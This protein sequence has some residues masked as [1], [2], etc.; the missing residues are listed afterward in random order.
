MTR[1]ERAGPDFII[2]I[3]IPRPITGRRPSNPI[4]ECDDGDLCNTYLVVWGPDLYIEGVLVTNRKY[5]DFG[6]QGGRVGSAGF[7]GSTGSS[8]YDSQKP[9]TV[10]R[11]FAESPNNDRAYFLRDENVRKDA[12]NRL[13]FSFGATDFQPTEFPKDYPGLEEGSDGS[14]LRDTLAVSGACRTFP[15]PLIV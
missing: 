15:D 14:N 13:G 3:E 12:E 9:R 2:L 11:L 6:S 8:S 7:S 4:G 10:I 1:L 5:D